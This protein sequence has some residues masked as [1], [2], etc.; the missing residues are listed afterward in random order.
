V[1]RYGA[2]SA[3][4]GLD[5]EVPEGSCYALFGANGSGKTTLVRLV[6]GL[7]RPSGGELEVLGERLP[8]GIAAVRPRL[9]VLLEAPLL[10]RELSLGE[11]LRLYADLH[12]VASPAARVEEVASRMG[13]FWRL[14]DPLCSLS[15]GM[16]QRAAVAR[17]LLHDP[18]LLLLDEPFNGLDPEGCE[19]VEGV[20]RE[21]LARGGTVLLVTHDRARG[22]RLAGRSALLRDGELVAEGEPREVLERAGAV[23]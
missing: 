15:R 4:A 2:R 3:L 8:A 6:A 11:G 10:P 18:E 21:R 5:L 12:G 19:T 9:G 22:A 20:V 13:L 1:K 7:V 16:A 23:S 14:R 17:V